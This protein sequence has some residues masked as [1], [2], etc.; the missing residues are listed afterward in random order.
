MKWEKMFAN[1]EIDKGLTSKIYKQL[2]L[3]SLSL[4]IYI[5][6]HTYTHIYIYTY[7]NQV[8]QSKM[9]RLK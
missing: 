8:T 2:I 9:G 6:T 5:C 4:Y 1:Y 3:L 7:I